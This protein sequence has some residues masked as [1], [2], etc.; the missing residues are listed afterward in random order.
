MVCG[1]ISLF[2]RLT[3]L[4]HNTNSKTKWTHS[5]DGLGKP[6]TSKKKNLHC[7]AQGVLADDVDTVMAGG[8][9]RKSRLS[10]P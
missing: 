5:Y 7:H 4:I 3:C 10:T 1:D 8:K 9:Y 6:D 2:T